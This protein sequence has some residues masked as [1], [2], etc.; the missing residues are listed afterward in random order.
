MKTVV[1]RVLSACVVVNGVTFSKIASGLLVYLA[2]EKED[3]EDDLDWVIRKVLEMRVFGDDEGKMNFAVE[4]REILLVSQFTL[5]G[6][7]RRGRRPGFESAMPVTEA[8]DFWPRVVKR[9]EERHPRVSTGQFQADMQITC[10]NDG[11][12]TFWL[13]SKLR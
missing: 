9:F 8:R 12:A 6:D 4:G 7:F 11:P 1:Q 13:D 5:T 3:D 2:L 10:I